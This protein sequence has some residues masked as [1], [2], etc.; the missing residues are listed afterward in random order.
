M[1]KIQCKHAYTFALLLALGLVL[2][3][4]MQSSWADEMGARASF[5]KG[6][7]FARFGPMPD[8]STKQEPAGLEKPDLKDMSWRSVTLPHDWGIEGPFRMDTPEQHRQASVGRH[9]LVPK[10]LRGAR[11]GQGQTLLRRL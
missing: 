11:R 7:L 2:G 1:R 9:R 3:G 8:G 10:A 4:S 6:W 5:N